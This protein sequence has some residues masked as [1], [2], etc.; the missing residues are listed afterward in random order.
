MQKT[1]QLATDHSKAKIFVKFL[2]NVFG[3]GVSCRTLYC[4]FVI[5]I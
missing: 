3:V 2:L 5:Y 4:L 1:C